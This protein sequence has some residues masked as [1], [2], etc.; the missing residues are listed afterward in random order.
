MCK[1]GKK[2]QIRFCIKSVGEEF[3]LWKKRS[4]ILKIVGKN[5]AWKKG[6]RKK[7][8]LPFNI[9]AVNKINLGR[10]ERALKI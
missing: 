1:S 5:I 3:Q 4:V 2:G 10:G 9:K 6:N 7:Y 8:P